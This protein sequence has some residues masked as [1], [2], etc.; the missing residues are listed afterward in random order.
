MFYSC[1]SLRSLDLSSF[2]TINVEDMFSMFNSCKSLVSLDLSSF[3]T[4]NVKNMKNMF[5][6][7]FSLRSLDLSSFNTSN[8]EDMDCMF[9]NCRSLLSLDLSS[10]NIIN[11][12]Y[13]RAMFEGCS[14][15]KKENVKLNKNQTK[16]I[17]ENNQGNSNNKNPQFPLEKI[18]INEEIDKYKNKK[19][20]AREIVRFEP[21]FT[22]SI[23]EM[24]KETAYYQ[25]LSINSYYER[26]PNKLFPKGFF[27][28]KDPNL[29]SKLEAQIKQYNDDAEIMNEF[30]LSKA[31]DDF[32]PETMGIYVEILKHD[33]YIW[34]L[35]NRQLLI[36]NKFYSLVDEKTI[37]YIDY[38]KREED[39]S[40]I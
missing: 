12:K 5:Y 35:L 28:W 23:E 31:M 4:T 1:F 7:C 37:E 29:V 24:D 3:N 26:I 33:D 18:I 38:I 21:K 22:Q 39:N 17:Q 15:L 2:N 11:V 6:N 16:I 34:Q 36:Y 20:S 14:L 30:V 10:F 32:H 9:Y 19:L 13:M 40:K 25:F 8:V 27:N